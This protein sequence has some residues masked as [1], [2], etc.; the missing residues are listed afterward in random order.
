MMMACIPA[1]NL[2]L[3]Y[4]VV[5]LFFEFERLGSSVIGYGRT[6]SRINEYYRLTVRLRRG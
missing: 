6:F 2:K 3:E 1:N 5:Y 4:L